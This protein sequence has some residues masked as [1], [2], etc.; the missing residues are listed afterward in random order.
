MTI[1]LRQL[2][3]ESIGQYDLKEL[4]GTGGMGAVY[5]AHQRNLERDVAFKVM[6]LSYAMQREFVERFYREAKL[7]ASLEHPNIVPI[8]DYGAMEEWQYVVMRLLTGGSLAERVQQ[9][10]GKP[11][12]MGEIG[13]LLQQLA[14]AL[15]YAHSKNIVHRDIKS[16]NI[17]FDAHG[18]AYLVDFG[19]AK[20]IQDNS[21]RLTA[22]GMTVGT[23]TH[24]A[25]ELWSGDDA[26]AASDQY[27]LGVVVY[28]LL[29]GRVPFDATSPFAL[30]TRHLHETPDTIQKYAPHLSGD[31]DTILWRA[32]AK[33][34]S[35]RYPN[36]STFAREFNAIA[37][38]LAQPSTGIFTMELRRSLLNTDPAAKAG[39]IIDTP[40]FE[41]M[42]T[43]TPPSIPAPPSVKKPPP[44]ETRAVTPNTEPA[45]MPAPAGKAQGQ[46]PALKSLSALQ[47]AQAAD[48]IPMPDI[49]P[50]AAPKPVP[51]AVAAPSIPNPR[52]KQTASLPPLPDAA[53]DQP[54]ERIVFVEK[55]EQK[56]KDKREAD[57]CMTVLVDSFMNLFGITVSSTVRAS[58][59]LILTG[60]LTVALIVGA[61]V[62]IASFLT[63]PTANNIMTQIRASLDSIG[64]KANQSITIQPPSGGSIQVNTGQPTPLPLPP[65]QGGGFPPPPPPRR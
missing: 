20:L 35:E 62:I 19:I 10:R 64:S 16:N 13:A 65:Q 58:I 43:M 36:A 14:S 24:M 2:S 1:T 39:P 9:M 29:T 33:E 4:Y 38:R 26:S 47:K 27:A 51:V 12:S 59:A 17:M 30:M 5:R 56:P 42:P 46:R 40:Q 49:I 11:P 21:T 23:P 55:K 34:K 15:D 6:S 3:G 54:K 45:P 18:T 31:F 8:Y 57:G 22:D 37:Q 25:P 61:G 50:V 60:V 28:E 52:P 44:P 63:S 48:A 41:G 7:A 53:K 32:M